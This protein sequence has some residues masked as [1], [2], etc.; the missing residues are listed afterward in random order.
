M[1]ITAVKSKIRVWW[2]YAKKYVWV[3]VVVYI[4]HL[5]VEGLAVNLF[6][7]QVIQPLMA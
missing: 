6:Y 2:E 7:Y 4:I 5:T 1:T 3:A